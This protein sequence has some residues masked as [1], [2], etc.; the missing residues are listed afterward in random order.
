MIA[1]L[2]RGWTAPSD[3][4]DY[5]RLVT[6]EVFP[7]IADEAGAGFRGGEVLRREESEEVAFLTVLRF[8]SLDD[9]RAF[10]GEEYGAAHVPPE[11][12]ELLA[13]YEDRVE[14]Y[15]V[16]GSLEG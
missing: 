5:E 1:R 4:D 14:H 9:V 10:A 3:A 8:D 2:W 11:A 7:A 15:E 13:R 16:R 6:E 12:R